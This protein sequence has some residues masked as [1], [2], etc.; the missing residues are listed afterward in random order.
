LSLEPIP[1]KVGSEVMI[2]PLNFGSIKS[3]AD[4]ISPGFT[5][6]VFRKN[7]G[8]RVLNSR[9]TYCCSGSTKGSLPGFHFVS[10]VTSGSTNAGR[11]GSSIFSPKKTEVMVCW[12]ERA[13]S[14]V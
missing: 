4:L 7:I 9:S 12:P 13:A 6:L 5:Y 14:T 1:G 10:S 3:C 11:S 2:L 8:V